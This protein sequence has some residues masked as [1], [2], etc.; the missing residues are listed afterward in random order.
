MITKADLDLLEKDGWT[1]L[2]DGKSFV[3]DDYTIFYDVDYERP[4]Q[5]Y[6]GEHPIAEKY[7]VSGVL[8]RTQ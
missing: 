4:W 8:R 5:L 2:E 6:E 7:T 3:K 1:T